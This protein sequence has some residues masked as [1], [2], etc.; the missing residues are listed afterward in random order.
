MRVISSCKNCGCL[1]ARALLSRL[2]RRVGAVLAPS[3]RDLG[4]G[5]GSCGGEPVVLMIARA[6]FIGY[7]V[8]MLL[9]TTDTD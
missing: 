9:R 6:A 3:M 5:C 1:T 7:R 4:C 2:L 8:T